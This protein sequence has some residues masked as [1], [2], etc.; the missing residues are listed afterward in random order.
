MTWAVALRKKQIGSSLDGEELKYSFPPVV[1]AFLRSLV[2]ENVKDELWPEAN[3]LSL[4]KFCS[5]LDMP[6]TF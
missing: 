3:K 4:E 6:K 5:G 2:P 1:L